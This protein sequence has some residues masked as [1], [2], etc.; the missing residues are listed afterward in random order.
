M[1]ISAAMTLTFVSKLSKVEESDRYPT[2][3]SMEPGQCLKQVHVETSTANSI[4]TPSILYDR[5][6]GLVDGL[7]MKDTYVE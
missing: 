2:R 4:V 5:R 6:P 7:S 3:R 1:R